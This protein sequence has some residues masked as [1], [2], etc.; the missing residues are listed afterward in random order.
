M[1]NDVL[2][3][4]LL[5]LVALVV[6]AGI[7]DYDRAAALWEARIAGLETELADTVRQN[8]RCDYQ[9]IQCEAN[10]V[11]VIHN[12]ERVESTLERCVVFP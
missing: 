8:E 10:Y 11:R 1:R 4:L 7:S 2:G 5:A 3:A 12:L 6:Y 9:V